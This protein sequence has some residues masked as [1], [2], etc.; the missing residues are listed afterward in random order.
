MNLFEIYYNAIANR[1]NTDME[2]AEEILKK[3]IGELKDELDA[4]D[5]EH[6]KELWNDHFC[7]ATYPSTE[8]FLLSIIMFGENPYIPKK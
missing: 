5:D 8:D 1:Y 7:G 6:A 2:G 3:Y 4:S